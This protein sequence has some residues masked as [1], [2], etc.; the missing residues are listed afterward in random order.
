MKP[1][2]LN[3]IS[4]GHVPTK[5]SNERVEIIMSHRRENS[6][7]LKHLIKRGILKKTKFFLD[8]PLRILVKFFVIIY[9]DLGCRLKLAP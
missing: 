1:E 5:R 3:I 4:N 9:S 7:D 8:D 6:F 2:T